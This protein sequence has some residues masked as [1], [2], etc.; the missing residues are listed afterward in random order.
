MLSLK[1]K[2]TAIGLCTMLTV[3]MYYAGKF[4][5]RATCAS[6]AAVQTLTYEIKGRERADEIDK[7]VDRMDSADID[8]AYSHWLR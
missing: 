1:N 3:A 4:V 8:T 2:L 5:E 7:Q 6:K